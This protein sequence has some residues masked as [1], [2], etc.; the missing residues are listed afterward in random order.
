MIKDIIY[1]YWENELPKVIPRDN[2]VDSGDL[3]NDIVGIRRCGKTFLMFSKIEELLKKVDKKSTIYI[4][5]EN[6]KLFPLN[7]KYF[8]DIMEFIYSEKLLEKGKIY[9]FLDE[10]QKIDGWEKSV[11]GIYDEFKGKI[12]IFVSGSNANLLSKDYGT[13]LTGRHISKTLMPLSF[14]EFLKFKDYSIEKALTEKDRANIKK[15][16]EEYLMFGGFPEVVLSENKEQMLSQLFNDI[17][18]RDILSRNIR[19]E[20]VLEEFAYYLAGNISSLLSFNKM[21]GYFKSRGIKASVPTLESYFGLIKN[22][23]L[24][25]DNLI[26]SYKIKDQFQNPRKIYCIDNGIFNFAGFKFS[27]DYGKMYEN[28]V[29]LKLK[30]ESFDNRLIHIFYWK[31]VL[32]EEVDFVVKEGIKV[33]Q[34]IQVCYNLDDLETKKREI[35]VL[36]KASEELKCNNLLIINKDYEGEEKRENR[37]IKFMPLWKWLLE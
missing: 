27:K 8:N 28:A 5:F 10:V 9:L 11:R 18:S 37:K 13:L 4:N 6:R 29:F 31:N 25:F 1:E 12:K 26:F 23:F 21:A 14:K 2:W 20:S 3:I 33:K 22:S 30:K 16:L 32:H 34:L 24:F 15:L 19:K 7:Q 35:K 17:L 36:L